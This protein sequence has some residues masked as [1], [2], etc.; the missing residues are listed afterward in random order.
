MREHYEKKSKIV[1][2]FLERKTINLKKKYKKRRRIRRTQAIVTKVR[3]KSITESVTDVE[4]VVSKHGL[5][6][7]GCVF[8]ITI[9]VKTTIELSSN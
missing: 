6:S 4:A 2:Y 9:F 7:F 1:L 5:M 3:K 8:W